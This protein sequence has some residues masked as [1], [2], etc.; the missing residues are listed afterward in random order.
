MTQSPRTEWEENP[1]LFGR[2][3]TPR[4]VA[5]EILP[6]AEEVRIFRRMDGK[7]V[8]ETVPFRP[9]MVIASKDHLKG[10]KD[11]VEVEKLE[12]GHPLAWR[13][14]LNGGLALENLKKHLQTKTRRTPT[15]VDAPY[16]YISDLTQQFLMDTG[17]THFKG[18]AFDELVRMQIDIETY[19]SPGYEFPNAQRE[20]DR[21]MSIALSDSLGWET[22]ISGREKSEAEMIEEVNALIRD[23]DPDAIEGHNLF[24]FDLTYIQARARR[25]GIKLGWGRNGATLESH[26]SRMQIGERSIAYTKHEVFGRHIVDTFILVQHYDVATRELESLGL[27]EVAI[28]FGIA[29]PDRTYIP[30]DR[31]NWYWENDPD[32]L[33]RY[34]LDDV[35]ETRKLSEILLP[36]F[37]A[38]ARIFPVTFQNSMLRG[39][40]VKI[41]SLFAREYLH[42]KHSIPLPDAP[43]PIQGGYTDLFFR[44]VESNVLH[45]DIT[46]LYPSVMLA[47]KVFPRKDPL[48]VFPRLLE[49]L[50]TFRIRAKDRAR[51]ARDPGERRDANAVQ[52]VFKILINSFYGYLGFDLGRFNDY[53]AANRVTEVGRNTIQAIMKGL[54]DR[55]A[56]AIELDTDGIYFVPP[57]GLSREEEDALVDEIVRSLPEGIHLELDG[58]YRAMFSYKMKNYVLLGEQGELLVKGSGLRSRGIERFQRQW[59]EEMFLLLLHGKR[60]AVERLHEDTKRKFERH[61]MPVRL[62]MKTETLQESPQNYLEKVKAKK[63]NVSAAYKLALESERPF[64]AGDQISYYVTGGSRKVKVYESCKLASEWNAKKPDENTDYY[65]AKLTELYEKFRPFVEAEPGRNVTVDD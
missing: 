59:M 32:T 30:P 54:T 43:E 49:D 10:F 13:V 18:M 45:C 9:F 38:Q 4:I 33:L 50:R 44:G 56:K 61:E 39:N 35:R 16:L 3:P 31:I 8:E 14:R 41:D 25:Y 52:S 58:R 51:T 6:G 63:R 57:K 34:N 46:S 55:G 1:I 19:C 60:E 15:A 2:D 64:Q 20:A 21:I 28:H 26:P 37:F 53:A 7:L 12:G 65:V 23:R 27:K 22:V 5:V 40:A 62:F 17:R 36:S 29:S 24:R 47:Y 11:P 42:R 48:G